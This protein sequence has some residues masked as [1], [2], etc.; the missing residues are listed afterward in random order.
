MKTT[1]E[2][3]KYFCIKYNGDWEKVFEAIK[4]KE[5]I[6]E[7]LFSEMDLNN[8]KVKSKTIMESDYSDSFKGFYKPPFCL[9]YEGDEKLFDP[10]V[11]SITL[12]YGNPDKYNQNEPE[13]LRQTLEILKEIPKEI[14]LK[15]AFDIN[16]K[17]Q[18]VII[19]KAMSEERKLIVFTPSILDMNKNKEE[20]D[21][22][23]Y[24]TSGNGVI[25][26]E[27]FISDEKNYDLKVNRNNHLVGSTSYLLL[28]ASAEKSSDKNVVITSALSNGKEIYVAPHLYGSNTLNNQL[29]SEGA[30]PLC[31]SEQIPE[32][33]RK[34]EGFI[35]LQKINGK[36]KE[37][38]GR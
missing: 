26:S 38:G 31:D 16:N 15:F 25:I 24:C 34:N 33:F 11:P 6:D 27:S 7:K 19:A 32:Y 36:D 17:F 37:I 20:Q 28:V 8:L 3:V 10:D 30:E 4:T 12:Y 2:V 18:N 1:I 23:E 5:V 22:F 9:F 29:I 14:P 13:C 21:L 35:K